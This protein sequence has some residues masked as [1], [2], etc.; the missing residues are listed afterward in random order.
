MMTRANLAHSQFCSFAMGIVNCV[1]T[2]LESRERSFLSMLTRL[3]AV[4]RGYGRASMTLAP[5]E[6]R[7]ALTVGSL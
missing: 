3:L 6:L 1:G 4:S 7:L 2:C 5:K